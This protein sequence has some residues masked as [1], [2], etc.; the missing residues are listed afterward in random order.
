MKEHKALPEMAPVPKAY[1][2]IV[3]SL[4]SVLA[5]EF[6]LFTKTLNYHWNI[7]G[8][9][10]HSLHTFLGEQYNQLLA[11]MDEVAERV[12]VLDERPIHTIKGMYSSMEIKD[13]EVIT[14]STEMM[15]E[16]LLMDHL[17][18]Q[19]QLK[20][21]IMENKKFMD[22]PG[23]EDLLISILRKHEIMSWMLRSHLIK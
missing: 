5:N 16:N 7:T 9:R 21:I 15:I 22:D 12:R 6:S 17:T 11:M 4:N 13:G 23:S 8:P 3:F 19:S 18:I 20:E 1:K 14:P 10:F 2:E